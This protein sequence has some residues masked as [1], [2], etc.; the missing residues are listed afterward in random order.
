MRATIPSGPTAVLAP[1]LLAEP[2]STGA[3]MW[4]PNRRKCA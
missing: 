2:G 3:A 1:A 4:A